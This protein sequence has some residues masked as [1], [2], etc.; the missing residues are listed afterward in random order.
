MLPSFC[1]VAGNSRNL[2]KPNYF[3][4]LTPIAPAEARRICR[5]KGKSK[6]IEDP[7]YEPVIEFSR[8][9][10]SVQC[11][12]AENET[13]NEA[14]RYDPLF[15]DR[16][17]IVAPDQKD[18]LLLTDKHPIKEDH[19]Y[20]IPFLPTGKHVD[21]EVD[22]LKCVL[23]KMNDV[24]DLSEEPHFVYTLS[25]DRLYLVLT[26]DM[27]E[28][29]R[30]G[31]IEGLLAAK[32]GSKVMCR[33]K[34]G[35]SVCLPTKILSDMEE[36]K[37]M[38]NQ[39]YEGKGQN[40][41]VLAKQSHI[42]QYKK[43]KASKP[44]KEVLLDSTS[45][46]KKP[47]D[48]D[49][50]D[51]GQEEECGNTILK[52]DWEDR[53]SKLAQQYRSAINLLIMGSDWRDLIYPK[54]SAWTWEEFATIDTEAEDEKI[55]DLAV[56]NLSPIELAPE[57]LSP[58]FLQTK[59]VMNSDCVGFEAVPVYE[60]IQPFRSQPQEDLNQ[61]IDSLKL[62]SPTG[63][64]E[65]FNCL[66]TIMLL[67]FVREVS[68]VGDALTQGIR[69]AMVRTIRGTQFVNESNLQKMAG[70]VKMIHGMMVKVGDEDR[71]IVGQEVQLDQTSVFVPG[72]WLGTSGESRF[73]PGQTVQGP[74]GAGFI[75]GY[76]FSTES[77]KCFVAGQLF[78]TEGNQGK[79]FVAG[80][81]V[82]TMFGP[83]FIP[84]QTIRTDEGLKF[85]AGQTHKGKFFSGQ[86]FQ[87]VDGP[88]FVT[89]QTFDTPQG[90]RFIAG[91]ITEIDDEPTFVPGQCIKMDDITEFFPGLSVESPN[92]PIF[93][94]G[95]TLETDD[96]E[97]RFIPGRT[98]TLDNGGRHFVP[99]ETLI[100]KEGRQFVAGR[101]IE[102]DSMHRFVPMALTRS[103]E[104]SDFKLSWATSQENV[105]FKPGQPDG[106]PIDNNT[107][108]ALPWKKPDLGYMMQSEG[109]VKF[110]PTERTQ[111][112]LSA[113]SKMVPGQLLEVEDLPKFVP[114]KVIETAIG[115]RFI[116]G[117]IVKTNKGEQFV[118]GQ[119]V[120][121]KMGPKFVPGQVVETVEGKKFVPGQ[122]FDSKRGARFV[123][124][125]IL[126]T[127]YGPT[128][129]PGQVV[130]TDEGSRFVPGNV[131]ETNSGPQFVPGIVMDLGYSVKFVAG[132]IIETEDGPRYVAQETDDA[133]DERELIVQVFPV[134]P[135]ELRL[136]TAYPFAVLHYPINDGWI[137]DSRM[138]HQMAAA[139]VAVSRHTGNHL[140]DVKI[141]APE[142]KDESILGA[143]V[144]RKE[145]PVMEPP[146][147]PKKPKAK[148]P[149]P[150]PL[151]NNV[152]HIT[153]VQDPPSP[154]PSPPP[155]VEVPP[156]S[157][158]PPVAAKIEI[159]P[160]KPSPPT[161]PP[162]PTPTIAKVEMSAPPPPVTI[163][164]A[165]T[166][167]LVTIERAETPPPVTIERAETPPRT[168]S[169]TPPVFLS[170]P[171]RRLSVKEGEP[172]KIAAQVNGDPAPL[173]TWTHN[174]HQPERGVVTND[175][176]GHVALEIPVA[177]KSDE[178]AYKIEL[179]NELGV[180]T[181]KVAV[182]VVRKPPS[183]PT[184]LTP[185][186]ISV[187]EGSPFKITAIV[188]GDP[189]PTV[190]WTRDGVPIP[191]D[192][193]MVSF[194]GDKCSMEIASALLED[195]GRYKLTIRHEG[196][197]AD[198]IVGV[199]VEAPPKP[200]KMAT[201]PPTD[202][203][204]PPGFL[205]PPMQDILVDEGDTIQIRAV[206]CGNP[207]PEVV[208][209]HN[210]HPIPASRGEVLVEGNNVT[211][212]IPKALKMDEGGYTIAL[213]SSL[214]E[215]SADVAVR[216]ETTPPPLSPPV[217]LSAPVSEISVDEGDIIKVTAVVGGDPLPEVVWTFNDE[218]LTPEQG[219]VK[220][221]GS[222]V[223]LEIPSAMKVHEGAYKIA[224][225]NKAGVQTADVQVRVE[226]PP[227]RV[228]TPPPE[229]LPPMAPKFLSAPTHNIAVD[230][231]DTIKIKALVD[232]HPAPEIVVMRD[233]Q[234]ISDD[235][236]T[237]RFEGQRMTVAIQKAA[238]HD[239]GHYRIA[240]KNDVGSD[241]VQVDVKVIIQPPA[242]PTLL[243]PNELLVDEGSPIRV[244]AMVGG[245]PHPE[246][247]WMLNGRPLPTD[248]AVT[249]IEG[250][251][252][253]L[254]IPHALK[255]D[256]GSYQLI[257]KNEGG[258]RDIKVS[259]RVRRL[260]PSKPQLLTPNEITV[261]EGSPINLEAIVT[262]DPRP[263]VT[264]S[265]NGRPVPSDRS[266]VL[267]EGEK[268]RMEI[269]QAQMNDTGEYTLTVK[270]ESGQHDTTISV[271]VQK[272]PPA[273]PKFLTP[274]EISVVEG[275]SFRLTA[276]V[277]G[278]PPPDVTWMHDD[279]PI[280][281]D[282][283]VVSFDGDKC[284]MEIPEAIMDDKGD[285]TLNVR[286]EGGEANAKVT[287][288]VEAPPKPVKL[289][290]PPPG[291]P[292]MAP[293]FLAL[294]TREISVDE[295]DTIT[296]RAVVCGN[297]PPEVVWTHNDQLIPASRSSV[298]VEGNNVTLVIPKAFKF[299][300]GGYKI[301]L[302]NS[303]GEQTADVDV[304]VESAPS[305]PTPPVT[306]PPPTPPPV[307]PP[308]PT[309]PPV[310]GLTDLSIDPDGL[311]DS[312]W[313]RIKRNLQSVE[314]DPYIHNTL[315]AAA[316]WAEA[317]KRL[318]VSKKIRELMDILKNTER[319]NDVATLIKQMLLLRNFRDTHQDPNADK[320]LQTAQNEP[321][322]LTVIRTSE[323]IRLITNS[324][325]EQRV[326]RKIH[327]EE[328][329]QLLAG[330]GRSDKE[331]WSYLWGKK[332]YSD[333][334]EGKISPG[335]ELPPIV[336]RRPP[337]GANPRKVSS[338][339]S[340]FV[341]MSDMTEEGSEPA[342]GDLPGIIASS[343][344]IP[345][346]MIDVLR[347]STDEA[348]KELYT[349]RILEAIGSGGIG[350]RRT[351]ACIIL[352][353]FLQTIVPRD[354]SH[355]V[356]TGDIDYMIIDDEGVRYFESA[357]GF[358]SRRNSRFDIRES[359][360]S[361]S[362]ST[363]CA[364]ET[365]GPWPWADV[366]PS[367]GPKTRR[368]SMEEFR[369][370]MQSPDIDP[371]MQFRPSTDYQALPLRRPGR[372][373]VATMPSSISRSSSGYMMPNSFDNFNRS[374]RGSIDEEFFAS[375]S[376]SALSLKRQRKVAVTST[377]HRMRF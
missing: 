351:S 335:E 247:V 85:A 262:G 126:V 342:G 257:V 29:V 250:D 310:Q 192:R 363:D 288:R 89:G 307:T 328:F 265:R 36:I 375:N 306:P 72:Q 115:I 129:V 76:F 356:L 64:S 188:L 131:V 300:E 365:A 92:G 208:W 150:V 376:P 33:L 97:T 183:P 211:L 276:V 170:R 70:E 198:G 228:L 43:R 232:G 246:V 279:R 110:L 272:R 104:E 28:A 326:T 5:L 119:V 360:R 361:R 303:L 116:P 217:F 284:T 103:D 66:E 90:G 98:M 133:L 229:G 260:P 273:P 41:Q 83:K 215:K 219:V 366:G 19:C 40:V 160:P 107:F 52:A 57:S 118:P 319:D 224:L 152:V 88:R 11:S 177:Q 203:P 21:K 20:A 101:I 10:K 136:I 173:V 51:E 318:D 225:K 187:V 348:K 241:A 353:D 309:P 174:D 149:S 337:R 178:G 128:F 213:K 31:E 124:G 226:S 135:E 24:T 99:G 242:M 6:T 339:S 120:E 295:G 181:A 42:R 182:D 169:P 163:E 346:E 210:G 254:N 324:L 172:I 17:F 106:L 277:D 176:A 322:Q 145:D 122:V 73:L 298:Q 158:P 47:K 238:K 15:Y 93:I 14:R 60:S 157:P 332:N 55:R 370:R 18:S 77:G 345:A 220:V 130:Y 255:S 364:P 140:Y 340:S 301:S 199:T 374:R 109:K 349:K 314:D 96:E 371:A 164:R 292:P 125:Q 263:S 1:R 253:S 79:R 352:K 22:T 162:A 112:D 26:G 264:W 350:G 293:G 155:V 313:R 251:E 27:E 16:A 206:V 13:G 308:P 180:R 227:P 333:I 7:N 186:E 355:Q 121:T 275:S 39:F 81:A 321:T 236:C 190:I 100:A 167:P 282:R 102:I 330:D 184:F 144:F 259:V 244:A 68:S 61:A 95:Q 336:K 344:D 171:E 367:P 266:M 294:P 245:Q 286:N 222:R 193:S 278:D 271:K 354:A 290:S 359:Q 231:G 179:K 94:P 4:L 274:S 377:E 86:I 49:D 234:I 325:E 53:I 50:E 249:S 166:P 114:G 137:I 154:P 338:R 91:Q 191:S 216:V 218:E 261:L 200:V 202:P 280:D 343:K 316:G 46:N 334:L 291:E 139:G 168:P 239:E 235:R 315:A 147:K 23:N 32:S 311:Y 123:P 58:G 113:D 214:G 189:R 148:S 323:R 35:P 194:D 175:N 221:D 357:S 240:L 258:Q 48:A 30:K 195:T 287:V 312:F 237:V 108:S 372:H 84:G 270:N 267:F 37:R 134:S 59:G 138:L 80:Q 8:T 127:K 297:P 223:T 331:N 196:G 34:N 320:L 82:Q 44:E 233:D 56:Y 74:E 207:P 3:P 369:R 185:S 65:I 105:W 69:G 146:P 63:I 197:E 248:R 362:S 304:H 373:S 299:D 25:D 317:N 327:E 269:G 142:D 305:P 87:T 285:Y 151:E 67:P 45:V 71:F 75:P 9:S 329:R 209:K 156:P 205:S 161:P 358:A 283:S 12:D 201:P 230:E 341:M 2:P 132:Q 111:T 38:A 347:Y 252:C 212:V 117:Q 62:E 243:T 153:A 54:V 159:S 281:T 302:K 143:N 289:P 296:I 141:S 165:E 256:E 204:V 78:D 368:I 268:C